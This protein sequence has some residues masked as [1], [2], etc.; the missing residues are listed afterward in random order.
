MGEKTNLP[1]KQALSYKNIKRDLKGSTLALLI[2]AV[3][4]AMVALFLLRIVFFKKLDSIEKCVYSFFSL[5]ACSATFSTLIATVCTYQ[6][7]RKFEIVSDKLIELNVE[8]K[9]FCGIPKE[10]K[11]VF[12]FENQGSYV[13]AEQLYGAKNYRW[14]K[15]C[16]ISNTELYENSDLEDEFYLVVSSGKNAKILLIYNKKSFEMQ[17]N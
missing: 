11:F 3:V 17:E 15:I 10:P 1:Q 14:S 9:K 4:L 16:K 5:M 2:A 6:R 12:T 7:R 8:R 13:V